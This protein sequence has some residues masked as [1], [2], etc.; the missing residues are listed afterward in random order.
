MQTAALAQ[1]PLRVLQLVESA[2]SG[3]GRHVMDLSMG[4]L[5]HG[6]S[7]HLVYSSVRR[8]QRFESGLRPLTAQPGCR[9]VARRIS[10]SAAHR[11]YGR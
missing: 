5:W 2:N 7:V 10:R 9:L 11:T 1:R 4:L 3:V 6:H 8:D